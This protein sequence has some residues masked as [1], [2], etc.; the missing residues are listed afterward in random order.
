MAEGETDDPAS[1][2]FETGYRAYVHAMKEFWANVDVDAVVSQARR[3]RPVQPVGTPGTFHGELMGTFHFH[4]MG[5]FHGRMFPFGTFG[6]FGTLGTFGT[7]GCSVG[8]AEEER[9]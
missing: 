8:P 1:D 5:T 2:P 6:T 3:Q 7:Y 4:P 9:A